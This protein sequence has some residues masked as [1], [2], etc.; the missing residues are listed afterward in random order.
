MMEMETEMG[1]A[2]MPEDQLPPQAQPPPQQQRLS[3]LSWNVAALKALAKQTPPP[4]NWLRAKLEELGAPSL[5]CLQEHKVARDALTVDVAMVDGYF[6][7]LA[8]PAKAS[9]AYRCYVQ[10]NARLDERWQTVPRCEHCTHDT[11]F[12]FITTPPCS[13][14]RRGDLRQG[15]RQGAGRRG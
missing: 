5:V 14:Q 1:E 8:Y 13:L 15:G 10:G 6:A 3:I 4:L 7:F 2:A 11:H 12:H 9:A